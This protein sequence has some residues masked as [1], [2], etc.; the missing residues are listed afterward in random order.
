MH[1]ATVCMLLVLRWLHCFRMGI[2]QLD[3]F[4]DISQYLSME[5]NVVPWMTVKNVF[6]K[7]QLLF[8]QVLFHQQLQLNVMTSNI[9]NEN[10][11]MLKDL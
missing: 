5:T 2:Q 8:G 4:L 7:F 1:T 3:M 11:G 9:Y 10:V 6:L